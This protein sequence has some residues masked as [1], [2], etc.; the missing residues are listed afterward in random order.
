MKDYYIP[1]YTNELK[2]ALKRIT[3]QNYDHFKSKS[4]LYAIYFKVM[5]EKIDHV[6]KFYRE[7]SLAAYV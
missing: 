7:N 1:R 6:K 3:G 5:D 2:R 4:Q